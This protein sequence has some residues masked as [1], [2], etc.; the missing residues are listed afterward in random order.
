MVVY[1]LNKSHLVP[2]EGNVPQKV[3]SEEGVSYRHLK[4]FGCLA[5]VH[6]AKDQRGNLIP[7]SNCAYSSAMVKTNSAINYRT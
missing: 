6:I 3:W 4:V 7:R 5:Y 2:L 1:V